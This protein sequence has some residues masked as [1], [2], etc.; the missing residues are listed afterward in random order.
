MTNLPNPFS[1]SEQDISDFCDW[2][3]Q[4][5]LYQFYWHFKRLVDIG[6]R[7]DPISLA[8]VSSEV[9]SYT[10]TVEL[11]S[12]KILEDRGQS[13]RGNTL[14][15]KIPRIIRLHSST[16]FQLLDDFKPLTRTNNSTLRRRLAQIDRIRRGVNIAPILRILLKLQVIRNEGNHLGLSGFNRIEVND[17][18][19]SLVQASIIIWKA[20]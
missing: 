18:L 5:E 20:R 12:N 17:L 9:V 19:K 15:R 2:L 3:E 1:V 8:A 11:M 10:N 14:G 6:F 4:Q 16:L 13:P 7:N